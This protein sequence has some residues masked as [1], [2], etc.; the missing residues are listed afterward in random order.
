MITRF[1]SRHLIC[2][3]VKRRGE[4]GERRGKVGDT[5][6]TVY[7]VL[8]GYKGWLGRRRKASFWFVLFNNVFYFG[9][10]ISKKPQMGNGEFQ[11]LPF[12]YYVERARMRE[13]V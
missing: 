5:F 3:L 12:R 4:G 7:D 1:A 13:R 10:G 2:T 9:F 8:F 11:R 6:L